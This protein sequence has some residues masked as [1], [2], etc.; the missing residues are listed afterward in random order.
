MMPTNPQIRAVRDNLQG[1]SEETYNP[2]RAFNMGVL[3]K[4]ISKN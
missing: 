4:D 3:W 1:V 2:M